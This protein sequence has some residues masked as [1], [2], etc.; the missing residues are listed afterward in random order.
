MTP[1]EMLG[2]HTFRALLHITRSDH[3]ALPAQ[4]CSAVVVRPLGCRY[5]MSPPARDAAPWH[6]N[7]IIDLTP[8]PR[9]CSGG[10]R[11]AL[12][13]SRRRTRPRRS[14][15]GRSPGPPAAP[16]G[17]S[18]CGC[19]SVR[20]RCPADGSGW[21][22][23]PCSRDLPATGTGHR[24]GRDSSAGGG[25]RSAGGTGVG[26]GPGRVPAVTPLPGEGRGQLGVRGWVR[27]RSGYRP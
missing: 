7:P 23:P 24:T 14:R 4:I 6:R 12:R 25:E 1:S 19:P 26:Q 11:A 8:S 2:P 9:P 27:D 15:S 17:R 18:R 20:R 22:T 5:T 3:S 21:P 13:R 10:T 16:S